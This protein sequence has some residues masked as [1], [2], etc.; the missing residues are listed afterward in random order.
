MPT[1]ERFITDV[2]AQE[3][4]D[5]YLYLWEYKDEQGNLGW[6]WDV[7]GK[8][9]DTYDSDGFSFWDY[10]SVYMNHEAGYSNSSS[11]FINDMAEAGGRF[12]SQRS[13]EGLEFLGDNGFVNWWAG[14]SQSQAGDVNIMSI[15]DRNGADADYRAFRSGVNQMRNSPNTS[16]FNGIDNKSPYNWG[17]LSSIEMHSTNSRVGEMFRQ[18]ASNYP[19]IFH[20]I[21]GG[22]PFFIPSGCAQVNWIDG[23]DENRN[24]AWNPNICNYLLSP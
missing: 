14:F 13:E 3:L 12:W 22:D 18:N 2:S 1:D 19:V 23:K 24:T 21:G 4:Y 20:H 17:N 15:P 8:N 11:T 5:H 7:F 16:W 10:M 9:G 6:W